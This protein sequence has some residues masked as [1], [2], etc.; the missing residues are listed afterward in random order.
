MNEPR[1]LVK[2]KRRRL[3]L[4]FKLALLILS[5]TTLIFAVAFLFFYH[6]SKE[7]LLK[8][9]REGT[10]NLARASVLRIETVIAK[11]SETPRFL[12]AL[13]EQQQP[14]KRELY[15]FLYEF[16]HSSPDVIGSAAAFE[17]YA[18][19][20]EK[21]AFA[22]YCFRN[23]D[24]LELI[25]LEG[26]Y[27]YFLADWYLLPKYLEHPVW[28]EP[29]F[30]EGG[31]D[32]LMTSL[33]V[34]MFHR[35]AQERTFT[36]VITAD[37]SLTWLQEYVSK[38]SVYRSGYAF[39]VSRNGVFISTPD[40]R[41]I[42]RESLFSLAEA[43]GSPEMR[44]IGQDMTKGGEGFVKLPDFFLGRP[45][46]IT[47]MP[48]P[49]TGWSVGIVVPEDELYADL[50][51]L[52]RQV[53][54]IGVIGFC[55][56]FVVIVAISLSITRPLKILAGSSRE[57]AKGNLDAS[58]PSL[59][60]NDEVG[61][62]SHS[63][64]RMRLS[65]K[66]YVADLAETT[67][68]KERIES[69]LRIAHDIQMGI[70]PKIFPPFPEIRE[71]DVRALIEPAKEVGGD[72][73]DFFFVDDRKFCFVVGDVSDKGVPAALFMAVT[74]TLVGVVAMQGHPPGT[75]LAK[76]N[77]GLAQGNDSCMFVTLFLG[78]VDMHTGALDY[79]CAGH[80]APILLHRDGRIDRLEGADEPMAG[81]MED[82]EYTTLHAALEP[83]DMI[84]SYTDGVTEAMNQAGELFGEERLLAALREGL[85]RT[86]EEL[87]SVVRKHV[88]S[89]VAG[90]AQSDDITL[91]VM[92]YFGPD[93]QNK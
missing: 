92:T 57:I 84:F 18:F 2:R 8:D 21:R 62:L 56:L 70:L 28:S 81:T 15:R 49:S 29:Y 79:A 1:K 65:L 59:L 38:V 82:I 41:L 43:Q 73:Y 46:W 66:E 25:F 80:D 27:D 78:I 50:R 60:R 45:A 67:A 17:P 16:I 48:V 20:P 88:A 33:S 11:S 14:T 90:A 93:G 68:A 32:I 24:M 40:N 91:L 85:G 22:P 64:E 34:P 75:I 39:L 30:D 89:F 26:S 19:D 63:F 83:G 6:A 58:L 55:V 54:L 36:G 69:E 87:I 13:F 44:R 5:S 52:A 37:I 9:A 72:L 71:L 53:T 61:D 86:S 31:A 7:D 76:V 77:N 35:K 51:Q 74:K 23:H 47:Y 12:A 4:G 3:G 42:M 10:R